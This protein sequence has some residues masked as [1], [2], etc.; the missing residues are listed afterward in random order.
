VLG[1]RL[2][3]WVGDEPY[4]VVDALLLAILVDGG[5]RKARVRTQLD[6]HRRPC[7]PQTGHNALKNGH[8]PAACVGVA[9]AQHSRDQLAALT[10]EDDQRMVDVL[11]VVAMIVAAFLFAVG[12][13][14]CGVKVEQDPLGQ[15][16][17]A[18]LLDV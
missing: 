4:G 18:A 10:V 9:G 12:R 5:H 2:E 17:L 14:F 7:P 3:A 16:S 13:I 6:L 11:L 15:P 8:R 1:E